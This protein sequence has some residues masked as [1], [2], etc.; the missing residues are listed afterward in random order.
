MVYGSMIKSGSD[1]L[2]RS[3]VGCKEPEHGETKARKRRG[4]ARTMPPFFL[5]NILGKR[6]ESWLAY[7]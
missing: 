2:K 1:G 7:L 5:G 4:S 6:L 3:K